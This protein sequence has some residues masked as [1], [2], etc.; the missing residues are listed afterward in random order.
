M[1]GA[2]ISKIIWISALVFGT[3]AILGAYDLVVIKGISKYNFELL[4]AGYALLV[5]T[6][7]VKK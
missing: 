4:L 3:V 5:I 2:K 1:S 7:L 6:R